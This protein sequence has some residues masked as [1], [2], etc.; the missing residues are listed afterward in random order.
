MSQTKKALFRSAPERALVKS[1]IEDMLLAA[2]YIRMDGV[3]T[4]TTAPRHIFPDVMTDA[5]KIAE[6]CEGRR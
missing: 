5:E 4:T 3:E 6:A 2:L 1:E